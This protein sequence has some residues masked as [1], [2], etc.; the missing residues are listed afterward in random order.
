MVSLPS[1][2]LKGV[3][4]L[5]LCQKVE[6]LRLGSS[7]TKTRCGGGEAAARGGSFA[8]STKSQ[9]ALLTAEETQGED[10]TGACRVHE[11]KVAAVSGVPL[12]LPDGRLLQALAMACFFCSS[13]SAKP[14]GGRKRRGL[15]SKLTCRVHPLSLVRSQLVGIFFFLAW[16]LLCGA[17]KVTRRTQK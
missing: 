17:S 14:L 8:R 2:F 3:S 10:Q 4:L 1:Y 16:T 12:G 13:V 11:Q 15:P 6:A 9:Y 7:S 5:M